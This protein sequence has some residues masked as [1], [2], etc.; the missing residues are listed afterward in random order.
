MQIM[1]E[2]HNSHEDMVATQGL[3][4]PTIYGLSFQVYTNTHS[5]MFENAKRFVYHRKYLSTDAE[6][7]KAHFVA[8]NLATCELLYVE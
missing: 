8:E 5:Q 7:G 6:N 4:Q 1:S 3:S 2:Y